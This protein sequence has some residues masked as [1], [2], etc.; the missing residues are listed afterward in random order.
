MSRPLL[1][2]CGEPFCH[3]IIPQ[4]QQYCEQH[5]TK[6]W[7]QWQT[8]KSNHR[9]S[10]MAKALRQQDQRRYDQYKRDPEARAFY[11]SKSWRSVRDYVFAR[12]EATCQVCGNVIQDRKI[13][14]HIIPRRLLPT[15]VDMLATNNLWVLC[16]RCHWRKTKL[17]QMIT[18]QPNG[19]IKLGHL[20]RS[21][22]IKVLSEKKGQTL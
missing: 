4:S 8:V 6:H 18:D 19:D 1:H 22:W 9:K 15:R 16:Y 12:D 13:V 2:E 7:Q 11:Q 3:M 17:E 21:W 20:D 5:A 10:K 14:D